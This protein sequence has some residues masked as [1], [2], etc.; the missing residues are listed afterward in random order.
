MKKTSYRERLRLER[1]FCRSK[2][3][4]NKANFNTH[5]QDVLYYL[6]EKKKNKPKKPNKQKRKPHT[7]KPPYR[8]K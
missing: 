8:Y 2:G 4:E 5:S 3:E 6:G 1:T 7:E